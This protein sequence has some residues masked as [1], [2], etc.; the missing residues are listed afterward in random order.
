[1]WRNGA[2]CRRWRVRRFFN[3]WA[4]VSLLAL[5]SSVSSANAAKL[6]V[7]GSAQIQAAA[8]PDEHGLEV[9]GQLRDDAGR[10]ISGGQVR[11]QVI[12]APNGS[13]TSLPPPRACSPSP[14]AHYLAAND[15][16]S[17]AYLVRPDAGGYFCVQSAGPVTGR[18]VHLRYQ[19]DTHLLSQAE[20]TI[21]IERA[22]RSL[23]LAFSPE[24][25]PLRL[26]RR[27]HIV[28]VDSAIEP[29]FAATES[30]PALPLEL[31][32]R[33]D[34]KPPHRLGKV[35]V[36]AGERASF[37]IAS[38][39]LGNPGP[40]TLEVRFAGS[41]KVAPAIRKLPII[42]T[43]QVQLSLKEPVSFT[44][45]SQTAFA[46]L[47]VRSGDGPVPSGTVEARS[48]GQTLGIGPVSEGRAE[49]SLNA[50]AD[51]QH[52]LQVEFHY[53]PSEPW[54]L[55]GEPLVSV[56][57][58]PPPSP[59]RRLPWLVAALAIATWVM[60]AWRRPSRSERR[61]TETEPRP[62]GR[63]SLEVVSAGPPGTGWD[64]QVLDAHEGTA[65][66]GC[67]I[68]IV[69]PTFEGSS[70]VAEGL[71]DEAGYFRIE[72]VERASVDGAE[73]RAKARY[74]STLTRPLV[75][76][77]TLSIQLVSRRRTLLDRL[78]RWGNRHR[79]AWHLT[80]EPTPGQVA[81]A[82]A[83]RDDDRVADWA[84]QIEHAA[85]GPS[86]PDEQRERQL[87]EKE[88]G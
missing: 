66:A 23:T 14:P 31:S 28:F 81:A 60:I 4:S 24:P 67:S 78:V 58:L 19:P 87:R 50:N 22:R 39:A 9:K 44:H 74:H 80:A 68:Q 1:M 82:A 55:A 13:R 10:P 15:N 43:R 73:I 29:A 46:Q 84:Q 40:G 70:V 26:E 57:M 27:S 42:R 21:A 38:E 51:A 35:T 32:F 7:R 6:Q 83:H 88:P 64:G 8:F 65:I 52:E 34:G 12:D 41:P 2:D 48:N 75:A 16:Q 62:T 18:R 11:V 79:Q 76:S 86:A 59:W 63:S 3:R 53:L 69:V 77:G 49:L 37:E 54:W 85:F 20:L 5:A 17:A 33:G 71:S 47:S 30:A 25:A 45:G 61:R 72:P 36:R 56:L